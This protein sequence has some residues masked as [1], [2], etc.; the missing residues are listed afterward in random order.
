[1]PRLSRILA[2]AG[3]RKKETPLA[4]SGVNCDQFGLAVSATVRATPGAVRAT[5]PSAA[6]EPSASV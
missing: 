6:M 2:K 1:M 4:R 5:A 3:M